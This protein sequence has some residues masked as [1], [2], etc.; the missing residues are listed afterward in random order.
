MLFGLVML[1]KRLV[2][3]ESQRRLPGPDA[4]GPLLSVKTTMPNPQV[5]PTITG[6]GSAKEP[7]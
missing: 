1:Y 4:H 7:S 5:K 6:E 2:W 3:G